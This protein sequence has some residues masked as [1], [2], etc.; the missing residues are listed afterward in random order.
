VGTDGFGNERI[1][2]SDGSN[3]NVYVFDTSDNLKLTIPP[4]TGNEGT[5]DAATDSLGNVY[6]ADYRNDR[7]DKYNA[8]GVLQFMW[9]GSGAPTCKQ[10]SKPTGIDVDSSG[11]VYVASSNLD[12]VKEFNG[13]DGSCVT[14]VS[15]GNTYGT[16]GSGAQQLSQLRHVAV[17][18]GASPLV[19]ASDLWGL[20]VLTYNQDG[21]F[22]TT[23]P[24][25][26]NGVVPPAGGLNEVHGI[27]VTSSYVFA[28]DTVNM[29]M[30]RF[31]TDGTS[32]FAWST[33]TPESPTGFNWAQGIGVDPVSGN[34]WVAD[35]KNNTIEEFT[36]GGTA[37]RILGAATY[38]FFWPTAVSFDPLG[39]MYVADT[40]NSQI[41]SFAVPTSG[42]PT[43]RWAVSTGGGTIGAFSHPFDV[44][45]DGTQSSARLLVTD[46]FN[47][48]LV[49]LDPANGNG[50]AV[51][52]MSKGSGNG[53]VTSPEGVTVA[54]NG[55]IWVTDTGNNRVEEFNPD[56]TFANEL[57]G[58]YGT[59]NS[60]LNAPQG[61]QIGPDGLLYIADT[62]NNR[63]Q[64]F[65]PV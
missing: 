11:H 16:K 4:T 65:Q 19:F 8:S 31:N 62:S 40:N 3:G 28:A 1:L 50:V 64:V 32:P 47:N 53:Q 12:V 46:T 59:S 52:P 39:N 57:M 49:T 37:L 60:Q 29:R 24:E 35:T 63:I 22:S 38:S 27:A 58:S 14:T 30:E 54:A 36:T 43:L 48:R 23:Q 51:L 44:V 21:S 18:T 56:G 5:R 61:I 41:E 2:V 13:T 26:G 55:M 45:Y 6:T 20:K 25:L 34:V 9:G 7:V 15:G 42:T 17:G 33:G 10:V